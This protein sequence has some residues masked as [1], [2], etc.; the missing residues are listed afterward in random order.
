MDEGAIRAQCGH[1]L[2]TLMSVMAAAVEEN[3][4]GGSLDV[5]EI[6]NESSVSSSYFGITEGLDANIMAFDACAAWLGLKEAVI[7]APAAKDLP[8]VRKAA[9]EGNLEF[10]AGAEQ[11]RKSAAPSDMPPDGWSAS[12]PYLAKVK[13]ASWLTAPLQK[14]TVE[15]R[16]ESWGEAR[17]V[18]HMEVD[19][20]GSGI[21]YNP[22]DSI[23]ICVPN[24]RYLV[25]EVAKV[26]KE[27]RTGEI[28]LESCVG[29]KGGGRQMS[30]DEMLMYDIDLTSLPKKASVF[31]LSQ[32]CGD[33]AEAKKMAWLCSKCKVGKELWSHF[34]EKQH[35]GLG[36]LLLLFPSCAPTLESLK[37]LAGLPPPRMYSIA[38]SPSGRRSNVAAVAYSVVNYCCSLDRSSS[39]G[40]DPPVIKRAGLATSYMEHLCAQWLHPSLLLRGGSN[41]A[42]VLRVFYKATINFRLPGSVAPPLLL[43]GPGTGVAPFIGFLEHRRHLESQRTQAHSQRSGEDDATMGLWRGAFELQEQDLQEELDDVEKYIASVPPGPVHL[44]FGCRNDDDYLFRGQL[45]S[46]LE[47]QTLSSLEV[48]RSRVGSSKEY[49]THRIRNRGVEVADILL[50]QGGYVYICGDGNQM[51]KDVHA[52]LLE[53]VTQHTDLDEKESVE[54]LADL[55][56]RRRYVLDVWS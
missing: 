16:L 30:V 35:L 31:A 38:S 24:P 22:G 53:V 47:D 49:V 28:S 37:S 51:A 26:I 23:G 40:E 13:S 18:V 32:C 50:R 9:S 56:V 1:Q 3:K 20:E 8:R 29:M 11:D 6:Q 39:N 7:E 48:A 41:Q 10:L 33:E 25:V 45:A 14:E 46:F 43:V 42:P 44:F 52:A 21:I 27:I 5:S 34:V 12:F 36:E 2:V 4:S 17:R 55:K 19:L 54:F 15:S